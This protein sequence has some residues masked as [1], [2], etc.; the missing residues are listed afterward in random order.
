MFFTVLDT[1]PKETRTSTR[2]QKKMVH[3]N[4]RDMYG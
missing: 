3:I 4:I 2:I 1:D